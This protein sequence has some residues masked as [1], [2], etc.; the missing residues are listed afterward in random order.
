MRERMKQFL[1]VFITVL[2]AAFIWQIV[3]DT[4]CCPA[5][6]S[7]SAVTVGDIDYDELT[8]KVYKNGNTIVYFSSD[9]RKTWTEVEGET[10]GDTNGGY[11]IMDISWVSPA[12][13]V[14]VYFKGNKVATALEVVFPKANSA[15][16][17]TFDKV[18]IDFEFDG[19]DDYTSFMWRKE[20]DY[21]WTTV[22]FDKAS[23][24]YKKF[25]KTINN[26]RY[27]GC[28]I[29][30]VCDQTIGT[31][32]DN[33]GHRATK[34]V[35]VSIPKI[36]NA[37]TVKVNIKNLTVNTKAN[38]EYYNE[39]TG[40]WV[41]C[42]KNMTVAELAPAAMYASSKVGDIVKLKIRVAATEKK[43]CSKT[44]VLTIPG[45]GKA[46]DFGDAGHVKVSLVKENI[47]LTFT[48]ASS[49]TPIEYCVVKSGVTFDP[50]TVKWTRVKKANY[51][52]KLTSKSAPDKSTVYIRF[53][54]VSANSAKN[55]ELVLPSSYAPYIINWPK[56]TETDDKT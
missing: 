46:P 49:S 42:T 11:I 21:K 25:L 32:A 5:E 6:A 9:G 52:V 12:S 7:E 2:A 17:V 24:G 39:S 1:K 44:A 34:E 19:N 45:Q 13:D 30:F 38:M 31:D 47:V 15:F 29:V 43:A 40:K 36:A 53:G 26:L 50:T 8:M 54:G 22:P 10:I 56:T 33:M 16:K 3:L 37:P 35:K 27:K 41:A 14:T 48:K 55:V 4:G 23:E 18:N 51:Q 20:A 28:K